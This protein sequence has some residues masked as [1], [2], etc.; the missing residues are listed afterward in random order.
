MLRD[1]L[2]IN[3]RPD[4]RPENIFQQREKR[5]VANV[6][7]AGQSLPAAQAHSDCRNNRLAA[8]ALEQIRSVVD[9]AIDTYGASRVAVVLGTSTS[10]IEA[11]E[12]AIQ[13]L[14]K[15]DQYTSGYDAI[16][17]V[18]SGLSDF[19][20]SYL[21]TTGPTF[22]I[23]T[24]CSSSSNA[25][26]SARRLLRLGL[27]DAVVT[28]GVD[29][30]CDLTF[31][32]FASL[33]ALSAS[34][35]KPF[36]HDRDGINLGEAAA[37]FLLSREPREVALFGGS[38]TSDAHHISAPD[39][40]GDGAYAAMSGALLDAGLQ[41]ADISYLNLHGTGTELNDAMESSAVNRLFG[42]HLSC[43]S[44][45]SMTGHTLG[46]SGALELAICWLLLTQKSNWRTPP[47]LYQEK[48]DKSLAS[49]N[50]SGQSATSMTRPRYCVS[51]SFAFGGS[52]VSLLVGRTGA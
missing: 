7:S 33:E 29:S 51:N 11:T 31:R 38:A 13:S 46:A 48:Q 16:Q 25:I 10:G 37:I 6:A 12:S 22:T 15:N 28:G 2:V 39:P 8:T 34:Y 50:L 40:T 24:A 52:N 21:G 1:K 41:P 32:G 49:I 26:L 23:S 43:S 9:L 44:T 30:H 20:S 19:V 36:A 47:M 14:A 4:P 35:C 45:K 18:F 3:G 27:C 17:G 42:S 5:Y